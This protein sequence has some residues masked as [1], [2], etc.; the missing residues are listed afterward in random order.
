M[1]NESREEVVDGNGFISA[2][3][4]RQVVTNLGE[5]LTDEE[6]DEIIREVDVEVT[7]EERRMH[8]GETERVA[9]E[10]EKYEDEANVVGRMQERVI[11]GIMNVPT[12]QATEDVELNPRDEVQDRALEQV[13]AMPVSRARVWIRVASCTRWRSTTRSRCSNGGIVDGVRLGRVEFE[14]G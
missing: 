14:E 12:P 4:L 1:V 6:V 13:V 2:A 8:P 7:K 9:Q 10:G 11:E 3:K 5:K